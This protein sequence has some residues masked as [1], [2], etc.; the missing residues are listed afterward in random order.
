MG[1]ESS[2]KMLFEAVLS[3]SKVVDSHVAFVVFST[4]ETE[5][6]LLS[7]LKFTKLLQ[8]FGTKINFCSV[9]EYIAMDDDPLAAI[10]CKKHAS[11]VVGIKQLRDNRL[12][13]F[14]TAGNTGAIIAC[15][16]FSLAPIG[17]IDRLALLAVLPAKKSPLAVVDVGGNVSCRAYH[18]VQFAHIG[19]AFQ[20]CSLGLSLPKIGLL[21]IGVESKKG[22]QAIQEAYKI[23]ETQANL[24]NPKI[25]FVGNVEGRDAFQGSVDVLITDGFTGNVFLKTSEGACALILQYLQDAIA[26]SSS[27]TL[28]HTWDDLQSRFCYEAYPGA[29]VCGVDGIVIKCHGAATKKA[30]KSSLLTATT[31]VQNNLLAKIKKELTN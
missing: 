10:R 20:K 1:S 22:T 8:K 12:D 26:H 28:H 15:S 17:D 7:D 13:A 31:F 14:V 11:L 24:P 25:A 3:A 30:M 18:L 5:A 16:T 21:N 9:R 29:L 6:Q 23:L 2:P 4:M 27:P 19:A